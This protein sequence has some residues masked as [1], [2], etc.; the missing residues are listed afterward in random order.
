MS[1]DELV[2]SHSS[3]AERFYRHV[4]TSVGIDACWPWLGSISASTGYG[5][6]FIGSRG[7]GTL[8]TMAAHRLS[9]VIHFGD[10]PAG[11]CVLHHCDY[12]PCVNP[13]HL[14]LGTKKDNSVDAA[15]KGRMGPQLYPEKY[16]AE[17]PDDLFWSHVKKTANCW[18]W[19][20]DGRPRF[21]PRIDGQPAWLTPRKYALETVLGP[22]DKNARITALC[23]N[24]KCVRPSHLVTK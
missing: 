16:A 11:L 10:I 21:T 12:R 14:W 15:E 19:D 1:D 3:I 24:A 2:L 8:R 22:I 9:W 13:R 20:T 23:G 7:E 4:D 5:S 6:S 17:T 18:L